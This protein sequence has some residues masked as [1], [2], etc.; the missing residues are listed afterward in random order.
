MEN[1]MEKILENERNGNWGS[2]RAYIYI[3][4]GLYYKGR[5]NYHIMVLDSLYPYIT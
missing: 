2:T 4:T 3:Y 5:N 1:Q